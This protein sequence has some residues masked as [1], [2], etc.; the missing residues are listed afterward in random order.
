M[1]RESKDGRSVCSA[2]RSRQREGRA[3]RID[4]Y[5]SSEL[6]TWCLSVSSRMSLYH[7]SVMS[8]K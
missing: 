7:V 8:L 4:V 2:S 5:E 1:E 3:R 6:G